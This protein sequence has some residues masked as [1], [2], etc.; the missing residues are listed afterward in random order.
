MWDRL[1]ARRIAAAAAGSL[2]G[3]SAGQSPTRRNIDGLPISTNSRFAWI[4]HLHA[5]YGWAVIE[6]RC[7]V[8]PTVKIIRPRVRR[9]LPRPIAR[10]PMA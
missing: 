3:M 5:F 6:E 10:W 1:A 8:D 9:T 2:G 4:S 7:D